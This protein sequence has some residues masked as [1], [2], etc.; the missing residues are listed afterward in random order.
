MT[1]HIIILNLK[2]ICVIILAFAGG[3]TAVII[4]VLTNI[5][6]S[7]R[8]REL[9][10]FMVLGYYDYE[11]TGHIFR[12]IYIMSF[13]AVLLGLPCGMGALSLIFHVLGFGAM[14]NVSWVVYVASPMIGLLFT[15]LVTFLLRK[16]ITNIDMNESLKILE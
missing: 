6:I 1:F 11:V 9:A 7:E 8:K 12:E 2:F 15:F 5:N 16:K 10:T 13:I 4:Y 3:L 14:D